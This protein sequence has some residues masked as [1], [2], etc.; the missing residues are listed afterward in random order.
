[1]TDAWVPLAD[2]YAR[3]RIGYSPEVYDTIAQFGL[4]RGATVLDLGCGTGI[5]T[6]TFASNG[7]TVTGLDP[8]PSM[9]EK[10]K[11]HVP[12]ATFVEGSAE[13]MP[14][15][16]ER[17][18]LVVSAQVFHWVDRAN[19]LAE[20]L[21]VLRPGGM[22]AIWWKHLMNQDPL[23]ELR[24]E[25]YRAIGKS[26]SPSGL[27]GGFKEFYAAPFVNQTLRVIPWRTAVSLDQ[28]LGYERSRCSVREEMGD[29]R[30]LYLAE[31]E[32]RIRERYGFGNPTIPLAYVH[33]LYLANKPL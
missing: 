2:D 15:P 24:L 19:A 17:F 14:F 28:Y 8:S 21:R 11:H 22:I 6:A 18:D 25:T 30:D 16:N 1:M 29:K 3:H 26:P 10:A 12:S 33:F 20:A 9:L 32:A 31:L 23:T 13:K 27:T 5:A 7:F 4:Q